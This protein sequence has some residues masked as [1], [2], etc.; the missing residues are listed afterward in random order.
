MPLGCHLKSKLMLI[1]KY[2]FLIDSKNI[3][4]RNAIKRFFRRSQQDASN[5][6]AL[7]QLKLLASQIPYI[8][9]YTKQTQIIYHKAYV[10]FVFG[11]GS[12]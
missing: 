1:V 5:K 4:L 7:Q 3:D 11:P 8:G 2:V 6:K 10:P 9:Q 12:F